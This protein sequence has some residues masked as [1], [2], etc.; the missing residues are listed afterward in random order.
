VYRSEVPTDGPQVPQLLSM[1]RD[2]RVIQT[3]AAYR[4]SLHNGDALGWA[5]FGSHE[6]LAGLLR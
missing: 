4:D 5:R 2:D 1:T 3:R 6:D